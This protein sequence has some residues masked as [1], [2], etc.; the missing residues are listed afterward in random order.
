VHV[1]KLAIREVDLAV[2]MLGPLGIITD[3]LLSVGP[4]ELALL[5]KV[6]IIKS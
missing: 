5:V 4:G 6:R 3:V 1:V 2:A